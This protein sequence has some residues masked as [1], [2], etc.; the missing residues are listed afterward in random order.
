MTAYQYLKELNTRIYLPGAEMKD[1]KYRDVTNTQISNW[2]K[3]SAV[4]INGHTPGPTDEIH[5]PIWQLIFFPNGKRR[6]TLADDIFLNPTEW[7]R[8][9]YQKTYERIYDKSI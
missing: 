9:Q 5:F 7:M 2:L 3:Q 1:G 6:C 8:Y 4:L